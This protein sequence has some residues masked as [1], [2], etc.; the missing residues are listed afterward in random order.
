M[1]KT[2]ELFD[3]TV[4]LPPEIKVQLIKKLLLSIHDVDHD[5]DLLWAVEAEKRAE[6][7]KCGKAKTKL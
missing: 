2:Q 3:E 4:S 6:E 5:I 1:I 7:I